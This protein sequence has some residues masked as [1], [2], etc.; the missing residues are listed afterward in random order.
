MKDDRNCASCAY[1]NK[2]TQQCVILR[3]PADSD[4]FCHLHSTNPIVCATC[5]NYIIGPSFYEYSTRGYVEVCQRCAKAL[6][7]CAGCKHGAHCAF[8]EDPSPLPKIVT[9]TIRQGNAVMQ[10]QVRNPERVRLLCEKCACWDIENMECDRE[11]NSCINQ[12]CIL[13]P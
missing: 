3:I 2:N 8:E 4:N 1:Y 12:K 11:Y 6:G 13:E 5:G 7:T 10:T 9:Q